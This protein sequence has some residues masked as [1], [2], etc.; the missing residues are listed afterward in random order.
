MSTEGESR[1]SKFVY[2][3]CDKGVKI[4]LSSMHQERKVSLE[5]SLP[6]RYLRLNVVEAQIMCMYN[7]H[8]VKNAGFTGS[9]VGADLGQ[10]ER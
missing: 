7:Y 6:R 8:G 2:K 5:S 4:L 3:I 10:P 1:K 9:V